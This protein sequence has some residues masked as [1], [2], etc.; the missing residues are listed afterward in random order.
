MP[1]FIKRKIMDKKIL[2]N[3]LQFAKF[4]K[5]LHCILCQQGEIIASNIATISHWLNDH[6]KAW[7]SGN[8]VSILELSYVDC[9]CGGF[10]SCWWTLAWRLVA[11]LVILNDYYLLLVTLAQGYLILH[12]SFCALICLSLLLLENSEKVN[13][14]LW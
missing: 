8:S 2:A 6:L 9:V 11:C 1:T 7:N 12:L 4:V 10:H 5:I 3:L 13:I 14:Q